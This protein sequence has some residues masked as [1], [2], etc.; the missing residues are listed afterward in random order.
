[1]NDQAAVR[2]ET[3][4]AL[5]EIQ[6][7]VARARQGDLEVLPQLRRFLDE[8]PEVWEQCGDLARHARDSWIDMIGGPDLAAKESL[9]RKSD[10]MTAEVAGRAP[11]P[12]ER[13]LAQRV[14]A[15]WLQVHHADAS[16]AQSGSVSIRQADYARRR[17]D[18]AHRRLLTA[19]GALAM[20]RKLLPTAVAGLDLAAQAAIAHSDESG[21]G[22]AAATDQPGSESAV[23]DG[24][25]EGLDRPD[26]L[27][28]FVS[29]GEVAGRGSKSPRAGKP[30]ISQAL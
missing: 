22:G 25:N 26:L 16:V 13:L 8:H 19:I 30:R 21:A 27:L 5:E 9:A 12:L 2:P 3:P 14:V 4:P 7:L 29:S 18:S 15:T 11:S 10:A 1:V 23:T 24:E 17:Q 6:E 28:S 20:I